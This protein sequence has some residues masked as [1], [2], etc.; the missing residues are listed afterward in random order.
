MDGNALT[1][2]VPYAPGFQ[3]D[4]YPVLARLRETDGVVPIPHPFLDVSTWLVLRYAAV[5]SLVTNGRV[6][7]PVEEGEPPSLNSAPPDHT[8]L[9]RLVQQGFSTGRIEG[10]RSRVQRI[11]DD[12]VDGFAGRGEADLIAEL[13]GPLPVIV[14]A[15]MLGVPAGEHD[16]VRRRTAGFLH[17]ESAEGRDESFKLSWEYLVDLVAAKR[18]RPGP[19]MTSALIAARDDEDRLSEDELVRMLLTLLVNGFAT[20]IWFIASAVHALLA[21]PGQQELLRRRPDL[22]P[23]AVEE[24]LRCEPVV[25][26]VT[27]VADEDL[28]VD[29]VRIPRGDLLITSFQS[30]NRDPRVFADPDRFDISRSPNPHLGFSHGIHRCLGAPLARMETRIVL[31]TLLRRLPGLALA[32]EP[33]WQPNKVV[34]GLEELPVTFTPTP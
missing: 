31:A 10:M 17:G 1:A 27:W 16:E 21:D 22:L 26:G 19:D 9:R 12:L 4:P 15:E 5:R 13:T 6:V 11:A 28:V 8:R 24:T 2:A 18:A 23:G 20:T 34:R 3:A 32:R 33:R 30:A 25:S 7:K 14:T 29:G